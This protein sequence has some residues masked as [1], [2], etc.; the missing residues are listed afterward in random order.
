M[1]KLKMTKYRK[2]SISLSLFLAANCVLMPA[3]NV[4]AETI[5]ISSWVLIDSGGHLDWKS[6]SKYSSELQ[7]AIKVWNGYKS[8][9]IRK[10]TSKT[11]LDVSITD[12]YELSAVAGV[13][14]KQGTITFNTFIMDNDSYGD[15]KRVHVCMHELGHAL[16]L[17]HNQSTDIMYEYV[18]DNTSLSANDKKS[19]D[20]SMMRVC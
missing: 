8:G 17:A 7:K 10:K 18:T 6:D 15:A 16:G 4:N 1:R 13:T 11:K 9:V 19:Y 2:L 3:M 20:H 12:A 5:R 14:T